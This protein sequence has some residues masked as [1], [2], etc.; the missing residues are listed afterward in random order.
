MNLK[1]WSWKLFD[2]INIS[3][4][5]ECSARRGIFCQTAPI[6]RQFWV[7]ELQNVWLFVQCLKSQTF[8]NS[9][10]QNRQDFLAKIV[11]TLHY[12]QQHSLSQ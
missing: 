2:P 7:Q 6:E 12:K 5:A 10:A 1:S 11:D 8:S 3:I 4:G 9:C